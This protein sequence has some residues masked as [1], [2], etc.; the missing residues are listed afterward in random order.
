MNLVP[1][2]AGLT[3][4]PNEVE[5]VDD[6]P[7]RRP[8]G[9][10]EDAR[11]VTAAAEMIGKVNGHC[12][13]VVRHKKAIMRLKPN[14]DFGVNCSIIRNV[15]VANAM[16]LQVWLAAPEGDCKG[17]RHMLIEQETRL[18]HVG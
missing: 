11:D 15:V 4:G 1:I 17:I 2:I 7:E 18:C 5:I 12:R 8:L 16:D 14:E 3:G 6:S 10:H 9:N 13:P